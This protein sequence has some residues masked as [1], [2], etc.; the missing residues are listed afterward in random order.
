MKHKILTV[1]EFDDFDEESRFDDDGTPNNGKT[2]GEDFKKI[3]D[4]ID[5][6]NNLEINNKVLYY[7]TKKQIKVSSFVGCICINDIVIQILPKICK[8]DDPDSVKFCKKIFEIMIDTL[9][10]N[11]NPDNWTQNHISIKKNNNIFDYI[12]RKY[13]LMVET[14]ITR[15]LP[16]LYNTMDSNENFL[17]GKLLINQNIKY[18]YVNKTKF[19]CEFDIFNEDTYSNKII[20]KSLIFLSKLTSNRDNLYKIQTLLNGFSEVKEL[21]KQIDEKRIIKSRDN[22]YNDVVK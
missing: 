11:I 17:K 13:L 5:K 8:L 6:Q 19:F 14:V 12:V 9:F 16:K 20:K 22:F 10:N 15:G 1:C 18:N 21:H 2:L 4:W 3:T 7:N